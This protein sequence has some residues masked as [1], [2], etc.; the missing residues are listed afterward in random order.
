MNAIMQ[1]RTSFLQLRE[2]EAL[3]GKITILKEIATLDAI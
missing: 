2:R 1:Y 3:V